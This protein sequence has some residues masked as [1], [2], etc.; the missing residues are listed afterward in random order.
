MLPDNFHCFIGVIE[1]PEREPDVIVAA[2][3]HEVR[4]EALTFILTT[5]PD[6]TIAVAFDAEGDLTTFLSDC[7]LPRDLADV[8]ALKDWHEAL[9]EATLQPLLTM[10][11]PH[12][13][14]A[15]NVYAWDRVGDT[16]GFVGRA[17]TETTSEAADPASPDPASPAS[18]SL[19]GQR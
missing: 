18:V 15:E 9:K 1:W 5:T 3:A 13:D 4:L 17:D 19:R 2:T 16:P 6:G 12:S 10:F 14:P 11:G 8:D 7:P